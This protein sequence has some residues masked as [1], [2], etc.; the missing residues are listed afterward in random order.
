MGFHGMSEI[1]GASFSAESSR[2]QSPSDQ[3][4]VHTRSY[5]TRV[6]LQTSGL[7]I[8]KNRKCRSKVCHFPAEN[9]FDSGW[10]N[11]YSSFRTPKVQPLSVSFS[12]PLLTVHLLASVSSAYGG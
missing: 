1:S 12:L 4:N 9:A 7:K 6:T 11:C 8:S 10:R 5:K 2:L 3:S